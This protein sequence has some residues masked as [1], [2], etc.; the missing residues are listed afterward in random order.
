MA[1]VPARRL[2]PRVKSAAILLAGALIGGLASCGQAEP[3][4]EI[5]QRV[6]TAT[7]TALPQGAVSLATLG[8]V[9]GPKADV[10]VPDGAEISYRI[11]QPNVVTM[12]FSAPSGGELVAFYSASLPAR[13]FV[14]TGSSEDSLTF[15]RP[16]WEGSFTSTAE[17][18]GFTLRKAPQPS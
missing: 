6:A 11:D 2:P 3:P 10:F 7:S 18:S 12:I 9:N 17:V 5:A 15:T 8:F 4:P 16:G 13:G 14:V 1:F